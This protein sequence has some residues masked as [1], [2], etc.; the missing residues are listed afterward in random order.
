MRTTTK[1]ERQGPVSFGGERRK[2]VK[3]SGV[4]KAQTTKVQI[5]VCSSES[6]EKTEHAKKSSKIAARIN[7]RLAQKGTEGRC[8]N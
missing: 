1:N 5:N 6:G 8:Q 4:N 2:S 7:I 3:V